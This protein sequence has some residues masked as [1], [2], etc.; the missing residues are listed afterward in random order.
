MTPRMLAEGVFV[1]LVAFLVTALTLHATFVR[2]M[3][4]VLAL[5]LVAGRLAPAAQSDPKPERP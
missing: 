3:W 5:G 1:A 4:I 2:N